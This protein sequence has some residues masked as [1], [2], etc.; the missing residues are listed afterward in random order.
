MIKNPIFKILIFFTITLVVVLSSVIWH[1]SPVDGVKGKVLGIAEE[2]TN[3]L[4]NRLDSVASKVVD[5]VKRLPIPHLPRTEQAQGKL[6]DNKD[7]LEKIEVTPFELNAVYGAVM[8]TQNNEILFNKEANKE[9]PIASITKLVTALVFLDNNPGWDGIYTITREDRRDGGK[10]YL[11][12]GERVKI[13]DLF[14]L[15][16]VG[17]ANTATIGLVHST[18]MTENEFVKKMNEKVKSLGLENTRFHDPVGLNNYN[19]STA[20]EI[21]KFAQVAL[22][23]KDITAATLTKKYEFTTQGGRRKVAYNTD[24]LLDIFPQNG[25]RILGGKTGYLMAS[26][27]CFVGKFTDHDGR[28]M[29]SVFLGGDTRSSRFTET[30]EL[31]EWAYENYV[32]Q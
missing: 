6:P 1:Y 11:Y 13:K 25:V 15:S 17:S 4:Y 12:T 23:N 8:D 20:K 29:I 16:L 18:G 7:K 5:G 2:N 22:S 32:W 24:D 19:I 31:I 9:W 10:I 26:G 28:E 3:Y 21:A 30:H 14:F 27:Y